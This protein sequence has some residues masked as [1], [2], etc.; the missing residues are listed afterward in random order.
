MSAIII[1]NV[2]FGYIL[3]IMGF[4]PITVVLV[5]VLLN[6]FQHLY[7]IYFLKNAIEFNVKKYMRDVMLPITYV[8]ILSIPLP[9]VAHQIMDGWYEHFFVFTISLFIA[10]TVVVA[11][12]LKRE[13]VSYMVLSLQNRYKRMNKAK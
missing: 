8:V 13:E 11:I 7:R 9:M 5:R 6:F 1:S 12:G 10:F 2:I 4:S 3:L